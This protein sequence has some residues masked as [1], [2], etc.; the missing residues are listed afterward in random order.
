[1]L[2]CACVLVCIHASVCVGLLL[3]L[4]LCACGRAGLEHGH[5]A[6]ELNSQKRAW[7]WPPEKYLDSVFMPWT[8]TAVS[9]TALRFMFVCFASV[10][11]E[12]LSREAPFGLLAPPKRFPQKCSH[13]PQSE[14]HQPPLVV[15]DRACSGFH[16]KDATSKLTSS[17]IPHPYFSD[18]FV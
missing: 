17:I 7:S 1:M 18:E 14:L 13:C 10:S 15:A 11:I 4:C 8:T 2:I 3:L 9:I 12:I 5:S 6:T 16:S